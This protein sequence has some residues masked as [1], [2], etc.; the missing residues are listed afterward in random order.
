MKK[1]LIF[2]FCL[3][4][5][6][7]ALS[8]QAQTNDFEIKSF[9]AD[10]IVNEDGTL[11]V[12]ETIQV[13]FNTERRGIFREIPRTY[14]LDEKKDIRVE[15]T[16]NGVYD[17]NGHPLE[18]VDTGYYSEVNLR[19]GNAEVYL[20]GPQTYVINYTVHAPYLY[21]SDHDELYW[22]VTG[23]D[24]EVPIERSS[25]T[26]YLPSGAL[27]TAGSCYTGEFGA[28]EEDCNLYA[29][30]KTV[31][32][33]GRGYLTVAVGFTPGIIDVVEP[34]IIDYAAIEAE[35]SAAEERYEQMMAL[36]RN[37][38]HL[39]WLLPLLALGIG[40]LRIRK[41]KDAIMYRGPVIAQFEAPDGLR[42]TEAGLLLDTKLHRR[43]FSAALVDLAV[44]GYIK[45]IEK[46]KG[47]TLKKLQEP[48]A[49]LRD[50][51]KELMKATFGSK[52][53]VDDKTMGRSLGYRVKRISNMIHERLVK[54]GYLSQ[55][56][57]KAR[58]KYSSG[59]IWYFVLFL[60]LG[61]Y[62][63]SYTFTA[64]PFAAA[65]LTALPVFGLGRLVTARTE[66]GVR[67]AKHIEGLILF[68]KKAEKYRVK[69]Q[70]QEGLF[71]KYLPYAMA[72]D[73]ARKWAKNFAHIHRELGDVVSNPKWYSG[74]GLKTFEPVKFSRHVAGFSAAVVTATKAPVVRASRSYSSSSSGRTKYRAP[75]SS[76][77]SHS[78]S[79][80][81]RSSGISSRSSSGRS[82]GGSSGG[83][84]GG[85]GGG[86]W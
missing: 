42:P 3:L 5:L 38:A 23:T 1:I 55:H 64:I 48:D 21:F 81:S 9:H 14:Q 76:G 63:S 82:S 29:V 12:L 36:R 34:E 51:E 11:D 83:G 67:A 68:I 78:R 39:A 20:T 2:V 80:S 33:T 58:K 86:S 28:V 22:N 31:E 66:K 30:G 27:M 73:L 71:E 37:G 57:D 74:S 45:I 65:L 26:I 19:I 32:V 25:A 50:W 62:G 43:D 84:Y 17:E 44:R 6:G 15:V 47:Y 13:N 18:Y 70:E 79:S 77:I 8:A 7:P 56:P 72:F 10:L 49:K 46:K 75:R 40:W 24:W 35:R 85:G 59:A 53:E 52:N 4:F 16:V 69:W 61:I 54:E 41:T 60:V